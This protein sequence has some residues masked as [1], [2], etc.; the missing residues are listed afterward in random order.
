MKKSWYVYVF[1][2][3]CLQTISAMPAKTQ[4]L[5]LAESTDLIARWLVAWGDRVSDKFRTISSPQILF[6]ISGTNVYGGCTDRDGIA[7]IPG[8]FFCPRTNTIVL[9]VNQLETLRR[10]FGDGAVVY[11]V[12]HEFGHWLQLALSLKRVY[13][14]YELQADCLAGALLKNANAAIS[15][16]S[17]DLA[18]MARTANA[19]GGG[20]HGSGQQRV[21][22]LAF[23]FTSGNVSSCIEEK[24]STVQTAQSHQIIKESKLPN[25]PPK[26]AIPVVARQDQLPK[27]AVPIS[28][29]ILW[30]RP[31]AGNLS[32]KTYF[33]S[34]ISRSISEI[35]TSNT[36]ELIAIS[37][38]ESFEN[39]FRFN[40]SLPYRNTY[41][42]RNEKLIFDSFIACNKAPEDQVVNVVEN[43]ISFNRLASTA[44]F[45]SVCPT[46]SI[47]SRLNIDSGNTKATNRYLPKN[48]ESYRIGSIHKIDCSKNDC[49]GVQTLG[50]VHARGKSFL[51][52]ASK[53]NRISEN[54]AWR[55]SNGYE[56]IISIQDA[57]SGEKYIQNLARVSCYQ[58]GARANGLISG[59]WPFRVTHQENEF[60]GGLAR[61]A[62]CES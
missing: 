50:L 44:I 40:Y 4:Q 27:K 9:E 47:P 58:K 28:P 5:S 14:D 42:R 2:W 31:Y 54:I 32:E 53:I 45:Y 11:A 10:R 55:F 20:D 59:Y 37:D 21:D 13:P 43:D 26:T 22:A 48:Y 17:D 18:E 61:E 35:R 1:V 30:I 51:I 49:T 15:L 34:S 36:K 56:F 12:A 29:R 62:L 41:E 38:V 6:G 46:A 19:I 24:Q 39:G 8:S 16:D 57:D 52:K 3:L 7:M 33:G 60:W 25:T 23:G